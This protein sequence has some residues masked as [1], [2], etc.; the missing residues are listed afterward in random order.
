MY[1]LC[2]DNNN[3]EVNVLLGVDN[4]WIRQCIYV[5][6]SLLASSHVKSIIVILNLLLYYFVQ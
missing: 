2:I 6:L 1:L 3:T 4:G 5:Q